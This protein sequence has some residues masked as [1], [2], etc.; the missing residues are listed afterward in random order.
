[1]L[2]APPP[3]YSHSSLR[4][5]LTADGAL[6]RR[7]QFLPMSKSATI[8]VSAGKKYYEVITVIEA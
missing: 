7:Q 4:V 5:R 3:I 2:R 8:D 1:M 6:S